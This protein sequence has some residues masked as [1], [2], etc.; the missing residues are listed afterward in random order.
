MLLFL[1]LSFKE[2]LFFNNTFLFKI[3]KPENI[4]TTI[5]YYDMYLNI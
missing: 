1:K 3:D 5:N 2:Y 4:N